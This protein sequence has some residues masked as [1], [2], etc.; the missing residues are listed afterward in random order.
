MA[1]K[2][3]I[4]QILHRD[5]QI[6]MLREGR[7]LMLEKYIE[8][9]CPYKVGDLIKIAGYSY[10]GKQMRINTIRLVSGFRGYEYLYGGQVVNKNGKV[11]ENYTDF[12][13]SI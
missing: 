5:A 12:T 9:N 3:T 1:E 13:Q 4:T 7:A 2:M 11:G 6:E 8:D 10:T